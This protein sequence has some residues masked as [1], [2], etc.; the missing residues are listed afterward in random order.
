MS[1]ACPTEPTALSAATSPLPSPCFQV[2][3]ACLHLAGAAGVVTV[4]ELVAAELV[5]AELAVAE[6]A[7]AELA[8]GAADGALLV[9]AVSPATAAPT[10]ARARRFIDTPFLFQVRH[11]SGGRGM[12]VP[13][14]I[15]G[16]GPGEPTNASP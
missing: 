12:P 2:S 8:A 9:H 5:A 16:V 1:P 11:M 14:W 15:I 13:G 7:V 3:Y 4:G 6:L 10:A